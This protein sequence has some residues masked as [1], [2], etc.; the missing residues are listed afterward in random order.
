MTNAGGDQTTRWQQFAVD[1]FGVLTFR[2]KLTIAAWNLF[3]LFLQRG[4]VRL[5]FR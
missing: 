4:Q 1:P 5:C 2:R 3:E